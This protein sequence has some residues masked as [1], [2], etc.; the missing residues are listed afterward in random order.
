M[1]LR[2]TSPDQPGWTRRRAGRG[3]TYLD[4]DGHRLT[5]TDRDRCEA[6]VIPPAWQ[7]VWITP[8]PH[9]HLQAVGTD[10]AGR[11]QYLYHPEW[12]RRRDEEKFERVLTF[13]AALASARTRVL[14]DLGGSGMPLERSCAAAVRLLDL[15][16]FR[17]GNDVYA[18]A[19]G[20]FG[21]TTL[22]RRHVRRK[23]EGLEFHF[24][25]KS[26]VE[27]RIEIADVGVVEAIAVM[28]R[29]RAA[30]DPRLLAYTERRRWRGL[31]PDLVN[32]YVREA[33]G[34]EATAKDFRTWHA[35]VLA[36]ASLAGASD[37]GEPGG[38]AASRK[39]AVSVAMKEV[40]AFLGN[41]PTLA[42]TSYVDPRVVLAYEEGRTIRAAVRR[43][44]ASP[45]ERQAD[46]ERA[47]LR[48]LGGPTQLP[49][50]D[51]SQVTLA[52]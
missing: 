41:T 44:H 29:R 23:G 11:R 2:R 7:D 20:H 28:R 43:S 36:A 17:I 26:G 50:P 46:L 32:T 15:G 38:T 21:L 48:L 52:S 1:R 12:R 33:T 27:H 39:R 24:V 18:D 30:E 49:L 6:L 8:Y 9:G 25:G 51:L 19:H 22:E 37:R 45:D 14:A 42:R 16:C 3:W 10:A 4:A 40:S 13:G 5:G 47:T 31:L 34:I 35:T